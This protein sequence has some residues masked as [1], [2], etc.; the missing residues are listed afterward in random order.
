M[1]KEC[2]LSTELLFGAVVFMEITM[3]ENHSEAFLDLE[4]SGSVLL[5]ETP[6][7]S[8]CDIKV[9]VLLLRFVS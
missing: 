4:P 9:M 3:Q 1:P 6:D 5:C 8:A 7:N 2:S